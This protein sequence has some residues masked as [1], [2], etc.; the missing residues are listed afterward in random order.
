MDAINITAITLA[1]ALLGGTLYYYNV[2]DKLPEAPSAGSPD[3][4]N[5]VGSL[6]YDYEFKY[7]M[8]DGTVKLSELYGQGK[9]VVINFWGTWCTG[10]MEELPHFDEIASEYSDIVT[11]LAIHTAG[12]LGAED[13]DLYIN[14]TFPNSEMLFVLD[15][16]GEYTDEYYTMLGGK[17]NYP[18]TFILDKDG[19]IS[20]IHDGEI[21]YDNLVKAIENAKNN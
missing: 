6:I 17:G 10:C 19:V 3:E 12:T 13:P 18:R 1:L 7:V 20:S 14:K 5:T 4:G 9:I 11:V 16:A 8:K 21:T 2:Y 15:K